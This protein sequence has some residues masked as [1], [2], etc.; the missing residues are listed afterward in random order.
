MKSLFK[1]L[2]F[3]VILS[4]LAIGACDQ[5]GDVDGFPGGGPSQRDD[6]PPPDPDAAEQLSVKFIDSRDAQETFEYFQY[7]VLPTFDAS[8][9]CKIDK[10]ETTNKDLS[11]VVD[12]NEQDLY[13]HGMRIEF[14]IPTAMCD[15][16]MFRNTWHY[17]QEFGYGPPAIWIRKYESDSGEPSGNP[18]CFVRNSDG[19]WYPSDPRLDG[20]PA[21]GGVIG[22]GEDCNSLDPNG[23]GLELFN[24]STQNNQPR[25]IY[26]KTPGGG[27]D[28]CCRGSYSLT[29]ETVDNEDT[30]GDTPDRISKGSETLT[31][32]AWGPDD[33]GECI[34]GT[35][36]VDAGWP[37][38]DD[39][40]PIARVYYTRE[41]GIA[42]RY[43]IPEPLNTFNQGDNHLVANW[44]AFV[45]GT[46]TRHEHAGPVTGRTSYLPIMF[47][48]I[49]DRSG[50]SLRAAQVPYEFHCL[51]EDFETIHRIR[52]YIR[53]YNTEA[54]FQN[55]I[56]NPINGSQDAD[57][58]GVEGG[59]GVNDCEGFLGNRCN[60]LSDIDDFA[61][62][63]PGDTPPYDCSASE[64][65]NFAPS[66]GTYTGCFPYS[67]D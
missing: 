13:F 29:L 36:V 19:V 28:N 60:D 66:S 37:K 56:A 39:G 1:F 62:N 5:G 64:G 43:E 18:E 48:P 8:S 45:E 10:I 25:C 9:T 42:D 34:S 58:S 41:Q 31:D 11:C 4:F 51:N 55:F 15:Y 65:A 54:Q 27:S 53:E 49:E 21:D 20:F 61:P 33:V 57:R 47:D 59:G 30:L 14:V 2:S 17:D 7:Q 22:T 12:V 40:T 52:W 67:R 32:L 23:T 50:N 63:V 35:A 3:F 24:I 26:D 6:G 16:F 44:H 46:D 38:N